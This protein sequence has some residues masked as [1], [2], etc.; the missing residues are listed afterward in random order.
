MVA[1]AWI[2]LAGA[3]KGTDAGKRPR[4][5]ADSLNLISKAKHQRAHG[6]TQKEQAGLVDLARRVAQS[7]Q[8]ESIW[9]L[10]PKVR[11][12]LRVRSRGQGRYTLVPEQGWV[13]P[14]HLFPLPHLLGAREGLARAEAERGHLGWV[15][16]TSSG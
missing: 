6:N 4:P 2:C 9:P 14:G 7:R 11:G 10:R 1:G 15:E 13:C 8:E 5:R 16:Q 12:G 3:V